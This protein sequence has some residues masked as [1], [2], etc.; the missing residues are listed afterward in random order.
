[1]SEPPAIDAA[2]HDS[3]ETYRVLFELESDA[4]FL[5]DNEAGQ[6]LEVNPAA[7]TLYG[8]SRAELLAK[9]NVDLSAEPEDTRAATHGRRPRVPVRYHR[10][11][12]G[13]VFPV[14]ITARHFL[15]RGREAHIA[16]IRDITDRQRADAALVRR[17]RQ[18]ETVRG[19]T[20][21]I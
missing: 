14:E 10:K 13:T 7:S 17:T 5:V 18:L 15:W 2:F 6:I 3:D 20:T 11:K 16:A 4:I 12:D 1:M 8:Y 21:E 19:I 9:R